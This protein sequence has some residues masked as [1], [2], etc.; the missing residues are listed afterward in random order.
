MISGMKKPEL[1][2]IMVRVRP[3]AKELLVRAAEDQ[4]RSQASVIEQL[5]LDNLGKYKTTD[6][7]I[8]EFL[9]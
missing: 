9:R 3:H 2:P 1:T 4:R 8:K 7:R 6:Q 5:L